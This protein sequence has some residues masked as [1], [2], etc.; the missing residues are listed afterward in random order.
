MLIC[1][2]Q[3]AYRRKSDSVFAYAFR[4]KLAVPIGKTAQSLRIRHHYMN[5]FSAF[6][7]QIL[8]RGQLKREVFF[9]IFTQKPVTHGARSAQQSE[10]VDSHNAGGHKP[11]R[12]QDRETPPDI[13]R[14]I[15]GLYSFAISDSPKFA[16]L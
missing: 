3:C 9:K 14:D 5:I 1:N 15:E 10:S 7:G 12:S 4:E 11:H 16:F 2:A 8:N 13:R 6:T